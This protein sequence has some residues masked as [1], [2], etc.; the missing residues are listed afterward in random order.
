MD[1]SNKSNNNGNMSATNKI[2]YLLCLI[3]QLFS[4]LMA[5]AAIF[6]IIDPLMKLAG[7]GVCSKDSGS[8]CCS[9]D[10]FCPPFISESPNGLYG[11]AGELIYYSQIDIAWPTN[12][13]MDFLRNS[14]ATPQRKE[15]LQ[16]IDL[17]PG[18]YKFLDIITPSKNLGFIYWPE[19]DEYANDANINKVPYLLDIS[20]YANPLIFGRADLTGTHKFLIKDIIV[21]HKPTSYVSTYNNSTDNFISSGVLQLG[22]GKVFQYINPEDG[23]D[24]YLIYNVNG[25]QATL[26][27]FMT[28]NTG[29]NVIPTTDDGYYIA[30]IEYNLKFNHAALVDKKLTT[31][32][33]SPINAVE[34]AVVNAEY[35]DIR[36]VLDKTGAL[37][38]INATVAC[39]N[40]SLLKFRGNL[41]EETAVIFDSEVKACL[42]ELKQKSTDYFDDGV[43]AASDRFT[44]D[45]SIDPELQFIK[46]DINITIKLKDKSGTLLVENVPQEIGDS[47]AK[48]ITLTPTL[49]TTSEVKYDGYESF[50]ATLTSKIAG[51]GDL[52][53]FLNSEPFATIINRENENESTAI[54]DRVLSYEFVDQTTKTYRRDNGDNFKTNFDQSDIADDVG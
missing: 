33:C 16:F 51:T 5:I 7:R 41:N 13:S 40:S 34:A 28:N 26:N 3:E 31:L 22:G 49:G 18:L 25:T 44:S 45:F 17:A 24:G 2:A 4:M 47:L 39:L 29:K 23:K 19:G 43:S 50:K 54:I 12:G 11:N 37:P 9:D 14:G 46:R 35:A 36:S 15:S 48:L 27:T 38:D 1:E 6:A 21:T 20:F 32:M 53:A 8:S 10:D 52:K 42:D 30:G